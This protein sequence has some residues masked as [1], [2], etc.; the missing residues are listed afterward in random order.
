MIA[1]QLLI[2]DQ[3][4][5]DKIGSY[6]LL[7]SKYAL[8][9][10]LHNLGDMRKL[11]SIMIVSTI[12]NKFKP[13]ECTLLSSVNYKLCKMHD[14][15]YVGV[16][17][18]SVNKKIL[19]YVIAEKKYH[20]SPTVPISY[21]LLLISLT[22]LGIFSF[23]LWFIFVPIKKKIEKNTKLLLSFISSDNNDDNAISHIEIDE[24]K[25][26]AKKFIDEHF[27]IT[28]LQKEKTFY[29][30]RKNIAEQVAH[31][32]RSPLAAINTALFDVSSIPES[33][34]I[35]IKNAAK[36]INDIANN[37]LLQSKN[38]FSV[39]NSVHV[40][41]DIQSELI[42]VLLDNIIAEKKY[43]FP[44]IQLNIE[45]VVSDGSYDCFA[46]INLGSFK[47]V[48]S[49]LINNSIEAIPSDGMVN[50]AIKSDGS[51]VY[52]SISDNGCGIPPDILPKVTEQGFSFNKKN[53]AGFGLSYAKQ[54]IEQLNG[55]INIQSKINIG[56]EI[57][58]SLPR[59]DS[60]PWFCNVLNIKPYSLIFVLDDDPSIHDAWE[61]K[62]SDI[63]NVKLFHFYSTL[64]LTLH[65]IR[66]LNADLHLIDYELLADAK[67]GLDVIE[68][69]KLN[70]AILVTSCF[71]D[72]VIRKR[73]ENLGVKIIPKS[74]VPYISIDLHSQ[75]M[76]RSLVFIDDDKMMRDTWSFCAEAVGVNISTYSSPSE[77]NKDMNIFNKDTDIYIDSEL[78]GNVKGEMYAKDLYENGFTN[79]YLSTGHAPNHFDKMPWIKSVVGKEPPF[80][81]SPQLGE[82]E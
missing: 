4:T 28:R 60:P 44:N 39:E 46:K 54:Y 76:S 26:I 53:G 45:L 81:L 14:N 34:R 43:E 55:R 50:L 67:S 79:I 70:N 5:I 73:C 82:V 8:E 40:D 12:E 68:D 19:G 36:R 80:L 2:K 58:I 51:N 66:E 25:I 61:Q 31:D 9:L 64:D 48:L 17:V 62:L 10:E 18:I 59:T 47:R 6:Q 16:S 71:E 24:Y 56:T 7:N 13:N 27:E 22:V 72:A 32:I 41:D 52:I 49:N 65:N 37:L 33:K 23:N 78:G 42:S 21:D 29:L 38:N 15:N 35:M 3:Y 77:F 69:L 11:D 75:P 74:F 30:T 20:L 57:L 1:D 63:P